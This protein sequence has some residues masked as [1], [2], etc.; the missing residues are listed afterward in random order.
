M[1]FATA[2]NGMDAPRE[3]VGRSPSPM[4][5]PLHSELSRSSETG[6]RQMS[7]VDALLFGPLLLGLQQ[8]LGPGLGTL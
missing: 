8:L 4:E 3:V 7:C 5:L 6:R 1:V 2:D